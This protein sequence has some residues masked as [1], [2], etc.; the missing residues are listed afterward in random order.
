MFCLAMIYIPERV[1]IRVEA[2]NPDRFQ[3][4]WGFQKSF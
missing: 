3:G 2:V 1:D 4:L